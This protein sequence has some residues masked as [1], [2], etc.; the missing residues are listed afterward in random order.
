VALASLKVGERCDKPLAVKDGR[1]VLP[2]AQLLER[3]TALAIVLLKN[4]F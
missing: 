4:V 2:Y 3:V 1:C